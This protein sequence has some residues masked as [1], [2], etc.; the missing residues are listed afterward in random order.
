MLLA[1]HE[2]LRRRG[3][4]GLNVLLIA[5]VDGP[6]RAGDLREAVR[7]VALA[8]PA[9][10]AR[11]DFTRIL[12]RAR[13]ALPTASSPEHAIAFEDLSDVSAGQAAEAALQG[14]LHE[15]IYLSRGLGIRIAFQQL[16][17]RRS[18]LA[19]RWPH[20]FMDLSGAMYLLN[21]LHA[22]LS[23]GSPEHG[24]DGASAPP[25]FATP[26]PLSLW[27]AARG[28]AR[29]LSYCLFNQPRLVRKPEGT[30]PTAR[31]MVRSF[32]PA[33]RREFE[34]VARER[35]SE[36][37]MRYSRA[38]MIAVMRSYLKMSRERG[39]P[40]K[41]LLCSHAMPLP[42]SD[43]RTSPY[44]NHVTLPWIAL[45]AD[46]L[47]SWTA[48]DAAA[49]RQLEQY[50][51]RR[52]DEANW[53]MLRAA[54]RWPFP[55]IRYLARHRHPRGAVGLTSFRFGDRPLRLGPAEITDLTVTGTMN[56]H[57]GWIVA[58]S[59]Y[60]DRFAISI[61]Y[62]ENFVD[63]LSMREFLDRLERTLLGDEP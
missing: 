17:A 61:G 41:R 7:A 49:R 33:E 36:G 34:R 18:R 44:G 21:E 57:P 1:T 4:C 15:S 20:C 11:L 59:M 22:V 42:G 50:T 48:A 37:P 3:Y 31:F 27:R 43:R 26:F 8:H 12:R 38:V 6:L 14:L 9:L 40:R 47:A 16:D 23:G 19:L 62:F 52:R 53:L 39:R 10:S 46:E 30:S 45:S 35:T 58:D 29:H 32:G 2:A 28:T 60:R 51:T 56:C 63:P 24:R 13:W 25:P 5:E 55:L 54:Q